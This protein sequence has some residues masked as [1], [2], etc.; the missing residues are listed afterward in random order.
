MADAADS[1]SAGFTI[2]WVQV[3]PSAVEEKERSQGNLETFSFSEAKTRLVPTV[4]VLRFASVVPEP[5]SPGRR[6]FSPAGSVSPRTDVPRTSWLLACRLGQSQY[7]GPPDV[8]ASRLPARSV[9]VPRSPGPRG[10]HHPQTLGHFYFPERMGYFPHVQG[11]LRFTT[12][13][14]EP[15]SH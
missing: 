11:R 9:P 14:P 4:Q 13:R 3:P 10:T 7:R 5:T 6:G 12:V 15:R 8:V 1:K 2:V